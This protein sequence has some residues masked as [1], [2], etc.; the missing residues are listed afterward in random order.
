MLAS[1]SGVA[2]DSVVPICQP[3]IYKELYRREL[4]MQHS[5]L[6]YDSMALELRSLTPVGSEGCR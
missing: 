5:M 1:Q 4:L 3:V 6:A 2:K